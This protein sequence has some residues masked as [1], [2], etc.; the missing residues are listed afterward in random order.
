MP[1]A[2]DD[3]SA[4]LFCSADAFARYVTCRLRQIDEAELVY[5]AHNIDVFA[6]V[7]TFKPLRPDVDVLPLASF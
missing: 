6:F 3:A 4:L 5:V 7:A 1:N 2:C